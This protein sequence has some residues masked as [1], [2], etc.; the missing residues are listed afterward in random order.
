MVIIVYC[1]IGAENAKEIID[2]LRP[3]K[4]CDDHLETCSVKLPSI[5]KLTLPAEGIF[6]LI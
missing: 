6:C 4:H 2:A 1:P 5:K 3:S